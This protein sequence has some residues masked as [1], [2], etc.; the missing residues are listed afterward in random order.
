MAAR[1]SATA[2]AAS[3]AAPDIDLGELPSLLGFH[4]RMAYVAM[5]R[6]FAESIADLDLTQ[7]QFAVLSIVAANDGPSQVD[8]ASA[9]GM[10]RASMMELVDRLEERSLM[11]RR[12]S[13]GDRRRQELYVTA[14]GRKLLTTAIARIGE[15]EQIFKKRFT[16]QDQSDLFRMLRR[17][18]DPA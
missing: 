8:I 13:K 6:H 7:R 11:E 12:R 16:A 9:L 15:H 14:P 3:Q 10:D 5:H 17:L 2:L 1:S 4:L 18:C